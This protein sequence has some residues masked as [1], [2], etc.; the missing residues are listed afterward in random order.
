MPEILI[1]IGVCVAFMLP[2][3]WVLRF[4]DRPLG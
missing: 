1:F 3:I 4:P 2:T